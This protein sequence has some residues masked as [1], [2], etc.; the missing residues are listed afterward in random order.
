MAMELAEKL[1]VKPGRKVALSDYDTDATPGYKQKPDTDGDLEKSTSKLAELQYRLYAENKRALLIVLQAMDTGGKDGTIRHVMSGLTPTGCVVKSSKVPT[2]EELSHD[3]LWRI[4]H[5]VPPRGEFGI[6]NRS[7]YEDVI[8]VRVHDLVPRSVWEKRYDEINA[9]ERH[10]VQNDVTILKFFLH[11]SKEEQKR[12]IQERIRD[13]ERRWK[14]TPS[15]FKERKHWAE[16]QRA[17]EDAISKC[18]TKWAPWYI[19]P[20]DKKWFR[21]LAV[22]RIMIETLESMKMKFPKASF[23]PTKLKLR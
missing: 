18:S 8:V 22:S 7:H 10:L 23:D 9:F 5:A 3:Y 11:I 16:Y 21:S 6:F 14:L 2:D 20:A 19:I 13:P 12:R 17:Y 4:H 15:D 1:R